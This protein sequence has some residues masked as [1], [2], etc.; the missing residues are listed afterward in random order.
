MFV[1]DDR[2]T[3]VVD[4]LRQ[5]SIQGAVGT[6]VWLK[7]RTP[8]PIQ[9]RP[10]AQLPS[11]PASPPQD[12]AK[13]APTQTQPSPQL[14]ATPTLSPQERANLIEGRDIYYDSDGLI[15]HRDAD[16]KPNGGDTAQREGWY[17]LGVWIRQ[18]T[19]GLQP[20]QPKRALTFEQVLKL[21]EPAGD[22]LGTKLPPV[23]QPYQI[24]G[25]GFTIEKFEG[26][27]LV[28]KTTALR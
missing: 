18:N 13:P 24:L 21:L 15:V 2:S 12:R 16:G 6:Q 23:I 25:Y 8:A 9:D 22:N 5:L 4:D 19:P 1:L 14:P 27:P 11:T 10:S 28:G 17:W 20:W 3:A 26:G 7:I